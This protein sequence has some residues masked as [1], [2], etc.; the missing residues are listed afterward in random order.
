MG[1]S[2][3]R[4]R[5]PG[6][7]VGFLAIT[8]SIFCMAGVISIIAITILNGQEQTPRK[9][10]PSLVQN[11]ETSAAT[12][13][14]T[15]S[16]AAPTGEAEQGSSKA[17]EGSQENPASETAG[18]EPEP[19][20]GQTTGEA[21]E[22]SAEQTAGG[23][24]EPSAEQT[25]GE[26][27]EPSAERTTKQAAEESGKE[28]SEH[29]SETDTSGESDPYLAFYG[30]KAAEIAAKEKVLAQ[31]SNLGIIVVPNNYLNMRSG[32][33]TDYEVVGIIFKYCGVDILE[34]KNGW[35]KIRS[36]G[37]EGYVSK[38]YVKTGSEAVSLAMD[39]MSFQATVI[40]ETLEV[41]YNN[42]ELGD[43][44][45]VMTYILQGEKYPVKGFYGNY[46]DVEAVETLDGYVKNGDVRCGFSLDEA[47]VFSLKGISQ[48]RKD[49]IN[50]A[51]QFYGGKYVW[52]G[53]NLETGVDCSG[54]TMLVYQKFGIKL[55]DIHFSGA[56]SNAGVR[57]NEET[58]KPGDLIFYV[59]RTPGVIGHVAIY[60]GNGKILHAASESKG[61]CVS[62]W[63]FVPPVIMKNVIG[64]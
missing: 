20:A 45:G 25:A 52:G 62:S 37:A 28:S 51:L 10:V 31:Y 14:E 57:V 42:P 7:I 59:G 43:S 24:E 50:Y 30:S 29:E 64:D 11:E 16:E 3:K 8:L 12:K 54:Y 61:I 53:E 5:K 56:Q 26:T 22:P 49:I 38:Q 6:R 23:T 47:I 39:H 13:K 34:E 46:V 35:Y 36:G 55:A 4:E 41:Y 33:S 18:E 27:E 2:G 48:K 19:S 40:P 15:T 60:I 58:I 32:P 1:K 44:G 17:G 63:K 9:E 21:A